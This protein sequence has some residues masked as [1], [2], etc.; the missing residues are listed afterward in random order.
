MKIAF[1]NESVTSSWQVP[2]SLLLFFSCIK[3]GLSLLLSSLDCE[4]SKDCIV[5]LIIIPI[6]FAFRQ[7][8]VAVSSRKSMVIV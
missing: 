5:T 3:Q 8:A 4:S 1:Q 7:S 6:M 2:L